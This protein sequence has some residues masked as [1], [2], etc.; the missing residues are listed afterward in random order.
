MKG[1]EGRNHEITVCLVICF[2]VTPGATSTYSF[3]N[4]TFSRAAAEPVGQGFRVRFFFVD[5]LEGEEGDI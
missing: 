4:R 2:V 3:Q 1:T 5:G